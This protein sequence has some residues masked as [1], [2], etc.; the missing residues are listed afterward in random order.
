[1]TEEEKC[2]W[3]SMARSKLLKIY[4]RQKRSDKPVKPEWKWGMTKNALCRELSRVNSENNTTRPFEVL[5]T[6]C[7]NDKANDASI[8]CDPANIAIKFHIKS[9][10]EKPMR[11]RILNELLHPSTDNSACGNIFGTTKKEKFNLLNNYC[12]DADTVAWAEHNDEIVSCLLF[13]NSFKFLDDPEGMYTYLGEKSKT[14]VETTPSIFH[15][16]ATNALDIS[17]TSLN[18]KELLF[19]CAKPGPQ[20]Y[21]SKLWNYF[22]ESRKWEKNDIVVALQSKN[23]FP[24]GDINHQ[25]TEQV[26]S[27]FYVKGGWKT[28]TAHS[29]ED[30]DYVWDD[31]GEDVYL[32]TET[33]GSS[34]KIWVKSLG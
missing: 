19:I 15:D 1:M 8:R 28:L 32:Y 14:A 17:T 21:G 33:D 10:I 20:K 12:D 30:S 34:E 3:P 25:K 7:M 16:L 13:S 22:L 4:H 27:K 29:N 2:P 9:T 26:T 18:V 11:R 24:N 23:V 6:M 31:E 5:R